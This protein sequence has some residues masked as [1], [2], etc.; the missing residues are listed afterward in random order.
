MSYQQMFVPR[1]V[2]FLVVLLLAGA[3]LLAACGGSESA[4]SSDQRLRVEGGEFEFS[5]STIEL[6]VGKAVTLEFVNTGTTEHDLQVMEMPATGAGHGHGSDG[7]VH[8]HAMPGKTDSIT[9]TPDDAGTYQFICTI[10]GHR[11]AGMTGTFVV[12]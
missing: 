7:D 10:P 11:E 4:S 6:E 3:L 12:R 1:R 2:L 5:P 9:F 8:A